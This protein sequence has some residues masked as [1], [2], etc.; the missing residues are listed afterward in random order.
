MPWLYHHYV[1][2]DNNRDF[3]MLTQKETRAVN[4]VLYR[5]WFP[6]VFLDEHQMGSLGPRMFVPPQADPLAAEVDS[7][8][9]RQA[10]QLG[11]AMSLRLEEAGRTG[12]GHDMIFDSYWP[13]GTRNTAWWK[14]VVGLL[15]EVA[16]VRIAT[17]IYID[18]GELRGGVK[19]LPEYQRRSNFPSPW[20]GGWW[21]L[22]DI[23]DYELVATR[24]LL[25]TVAQHRAQFLRNRAR[26]AQ[27]QVESGASAAPY[28]WVVPAAG[29]HDPVAA[30]KLV[31]LLLRHGIE[32]RRLSAPTTVGTTALPAGSTVFLAAQPYRGFLLT[33]LR[34]QRYPE[35]SAAVGSEILPPYDVTSWSLPIAMAVEVIELTEP[36]PAAVAAAMEPITEPAWPAPEEQAAGLAVAGY[37]I[38]RAAD[39][40]ATAVNRI[41]ARKATAVWSGPREFWVPSSELSATEVRRLVGDL[42]LPIRPLAAPPPGATARQRPVRVG[43]YKPWN[44]SMDEGWTRFLLE[45]YEFPFVNL[46]NEDLRAGKF[47]TRVDVLLFPAIDAETIEDGGEDEDEPSPYPPPYAGGLG[48][49]GGQHIAKWIRDGGTAVALDASAEYLIDLLHLPVENALEDA[50]GF[51]APGTSVRL[52]VATDHPLG[53]GLRREEVAYFADSPAFTTRIPAVRGEAIDRAVVARYPDDERDILVSGY[54]EGAELLERRAALVE[55]TVGKGR[56]ILFGFRPQHRAQTHGTFKFLWNALWRAGLER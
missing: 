48:K 27:I 44:A 41:L 1:G 32:A 24:A 2:H 16:S 52:L 21:H 43:L 5:R 39:T 6:Q 30:A 26:M 31:E 12:V 38:P 42:A 47:G 36:L 37:A 13:G 18:A 55:V 22:R 46:S 9:F 49:E 10:D 34:R 25:E 23:V 50:K 51:G 54:L 19:G 7:L 4:D 29:Q 45:G 35:V 33:M 14:G 17:P 8:I 28:G 15:T 56:V 3:F 40:A 53:W 20:P 11:T